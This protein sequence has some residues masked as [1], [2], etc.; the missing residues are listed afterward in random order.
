MNTQADPRKP[1]LPEP[2]DRAWRLAALPMLVVGLLLWVA[3]ILLGGY[4]LV[5]GGM[6]TAA[7]GA[8]KYTDR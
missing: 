5:V 8:Y 1:G 7:L 3:G 6:L 4:W 2:V